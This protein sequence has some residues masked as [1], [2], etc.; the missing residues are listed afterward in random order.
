MS[1]KL[2]AVAAAAALALTGLVG[3]AP[4]SANMT[5]AVKGNAATPSGQTASDGIAA[6]SAYSVNVPSADVIR[7]NEMTPASNTSSTALRL[8]VTKAA[9]D[10]SVTVST[11]GSVKVFSSTAFADSPTVAKAVTSLT[12]TSNSASIDI[13]VITTSTAAGSVVVS[14]AGNS[15][16]IF[17]K[18]L[19]VQPYKLVLTGPATAA[20]S[21]EF[22]ISGK[23]QDAFGND[24]TTAMD[25]AD[26]DDFTVT[27]VGATAVAAK[28]LY[29]STTKTY[30]WVF[31]APATATGT[32]VNIAVIHAK[33]SGTITAFGA[34][35]NSQFFSVNAVDLAA[36][37]T[38]LTAQVAALSAQITALTDEYNKLANR[39]NKRVTLKKAPTKKVVLK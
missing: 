20:L 39:F 28:T 23:V 9:A 8:T 21:G 25:P 15:R 38:S 2:I 37:V 13:Y 33:Q 22:T 17:V 30:S 5:I 18:G 7:T 19:S 16:T 31:T 27:T 34:P 12:D 24:L 10:T 35:V 36:Q 14:N 4:A 32:A 6:T 3:V 29:S 11:T 26:A 1:K